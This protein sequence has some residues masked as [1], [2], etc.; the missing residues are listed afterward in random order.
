MHIFF[1]VPLL[2]IDIRF[3]SGDNWTSAE[4]A[5]ITNRN[6]GLARK[7][8]ALRGSFKSDHLIYATGKP[9]P[10]DKFTCPETGRVFHGKIVQNASGVHAVTSA[11][12]YSDWLFQESVKNGVMAAEQAT[13]TIQS[14]NLQSAAA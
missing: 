11:Q 6:G 12:V 14:D 10:A 2:P 4:A 7:E 13:K 5:W 8:T 9:N 1:K 3:S